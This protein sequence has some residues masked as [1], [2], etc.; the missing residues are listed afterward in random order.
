MLLFGGDAT[1]AC[2]GHEAGGGGG[3]DE[4]LGAL[5]IVVFWGGP[6]GG[7]FAGAVGWFI[8]RLHYRIISVSNH[9]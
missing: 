1:L 9:P 8:G 2:D 7:V 6:V 5:G 4:G 3:E